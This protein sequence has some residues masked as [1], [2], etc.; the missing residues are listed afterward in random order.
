MTV[1]AALFWGLAR[2][3]HD[4]KV[5][6]ANIGPIWGRQDPGGSHVGHM[7]LAIWAHFPFVG[8]LYRTDH[9][10]TQSIREDVTYVTYSLIDWDLDQ[11]MMNKLFCFVLANWV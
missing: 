1:S 4:S 3:V 7:N 6:G 2:T 8:F 5:Y 10:V 11:P 9:D